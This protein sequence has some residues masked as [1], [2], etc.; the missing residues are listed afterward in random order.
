LGD[1]DIDMKV[2]VIVPTFNRAQYLGECLDSLLGQTVPP[3]EIIV[4]NDGSTDGTRNVLEGYEGRVKIFDKANGGKS[5]ALNKGLGEAKGEAIW[6]MD[7]DDV[8]LPDAMERHVRALAQ[9][10]DAGF[11]YSSYLRGVFPESRG[12][13]EANSKLKE[14]RMPPFSHDELFV[15][16]LEGCFIMQQGMVVRRRCFNEVG[17]FEESLIRSQDYEMN[18]RLVRRY[19]GVRIDE[20]TFCLRIHAGDRGMGKVRIP[21]DQNEEFWREVD[22]GVFGKIYETLPLVE[23]LP[24]NEQKTPSEGW[25]QKALTQRARVMA[26]KGLAA[27]AW[28][29]FVMAVDEAVR[30][31]LQEQ[32]V[33]LLY[34]LE[35]ECAFQGEPVVAR[36]MRMRMAKMA[37][38]MRAGAFGYLMK[39]YYYTS[40]F[41]RQRG[42]YGKGVRRLCHGM[43]VAASSVLHRIRMGRNG[44]MTRGVSHCPL[45]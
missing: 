45:P 39:R 34:E 41:L 14:V 13:Q 33:G 24:K 17:P 12:W 9:N 11:T 43:E 20:P 27:L 25:A 32:N 8:A 15:R 40:L 21:H 1:R 31:G 35:K 3:S 29:D 10:P 36:R 26:R 4:V 16:Y 42:L 2:S 5:S 30:S 22:K 19:R 6:I 37:G 38:R 44:E 23:Y 18:L 28:S 7:D